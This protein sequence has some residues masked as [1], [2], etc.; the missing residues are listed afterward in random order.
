M[1][2]IKIGK[3]GKVII[4]SCIILSVIIVV[5]GMMLV[6]LSNRSEEKS[7]SSIKEVFNYKFEKATLELEEEPFSINAT[8]KDDFGIAIDSDFVINCK[9]Q[10]DYNDIK[11]NL[12]FEPEVSY[13]INKK[14]DKEFL[15][16]LKEPLTE[17]AIVKISLDD[18]NSDKEYSWAFQTK[19]KFTLSNTL[20][21][22]G[23]TS[24]PVDSGIELNFS[25]GEIEDISKHFEIEP[26]VEGEFEKKDNTYVFIPE[27]LDTNTIYNVTVK[28]DLALKNSE[29]KLTEDY[30]FSFQT[31]KAEDHKFSFNKSFYTLTPEQPTVLDVHWDNKYESRPLNVNVYR[32][33][34]IDSFIKILEQREVDNF[35]DYKVNANSLE[36]ITSFETELQS[37]E[38]DW[39]NEYIVFPE[40]LDAG[41]YLVEVVIDGVNYYTQLQVHPYVVYMETDYDDTLVWVNDTSSKGS[42]SNAYVEYE[43]EVKGVTNENGLLVFDKDQSNNNKPYHYYYKI[44]EQGEL[45]FV[46]TLGYYINNTTKNDYWDYM[47]TDRN[48]YLATDTI[49]VWGVIK[50]KNNNEFKSDLKVVLEK[51]DRILLEKNVD[52]SEIGSY[53][54]ALSYENLPHGYYK[55][56][57]MDEDIILDT[58]YINITSYDKPIYNLEAKVDKTKLF[59]WESTNLDID[60]KF[61]D[62]TPASGMELAINSY[63]PNNDKHHGETTCND[64][65]EASYVFEEDVKS[66]SWRPKWININVSN[67]QAEEVEVRTTESIMVFPKDT[68]IEIVEDEQ[69]QY[70]VSTHKIDYNNYEDDYKSLRDDKV[71]IPIDVTITEIEYLKIEEGTY[72]DFINKKTQKKYRYDKKETIVQDIS[73]ETENGVYNIEYEYEDDKN[74]EI[75]VKAKDSRGSNIVE[76][77]YKNEYSVPSASSQKNYSLEMTEPSKW[78]FGLEEDVEIS[79]KCNNADITDTDIDQTLFIQ[80]K[81]GRSNTFLK[82]NSELVFPYDEE[83]IPNIFLSAIY[84]DG[85]GLYKSR[86]EIIGYKSEEKELQF[87]IE[88]DKETYKPGD[89][90]NLNIKVSDLQG[91]PQKADI[92]IS[93]VDE[94]FFEL[95]NHEANIL[96][97]LYEYDSTKGVL[98][99]YISYRQVDDFESGAENGGEGDDGSLRSDFKDTAFFNSIE[100][101]EQGNA[102]FKF[103]LPDNL[104]NWRITCQGVTKDLFAGDE[105]ININTQLPFFV[106]TI[107]GDTFIKGDE[108]KISL[109]TFGM[110]VESDELIVYEIVLKDDEGNKQRFTINGKSH[111]YTLVDLGKLDIGS[112]T[113]ETFAEN[114]K[115]KDG[116]QKSFDVVD[117]TLKF[118]YTE[119][120]NLTED[121]KFEPTQSYEKTTFINADNYFVYDT[122]M[123][124]S[125]DYGNRVDQKLARYLSSKWLEDFNDSNL[126]NITKNDFNPHQSSGIRLLPYSD[127]DVALTAKINSL[128]TD[129]FD[130]NYV[131]FYKHILNKEDVTKKEALAALYGLSVAKEPVLLELNKFNKDDLDIEDKLYLALGYAE[132]GAYKEARN[133]YYELINDYGRETDEYLYL[134]DGKDW[135]DRIKVTALGSV[136]GAKLQEDEAFMM[137]DFICDYPSEYYLANI[138][139]LMFIKEFKI[140]HSTASFTYLLNEK[141]EKVKLDNLDIKQLYLSKDELENI[142]FKNIK[143]NVIV[144]KDGL[145]TVND[146]KDQVAKDFEIKRNYSVDN[147]ETTNFNQSEL[148]KVTLTPSF[149]TNLSKG[150]YEITDSIPAGFRYVSPKH[151][152]GY[153]TFGEVDSQIR[154]YFYYDPESKDPIDEITYY[155]RATT[156]G[157]YTADYA[158]IKSSNTNKLAHTEQAEITIVK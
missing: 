117:S 60:A 145:G 42:L 1:K 82:N 106:T 125:Y 122:L 131:S 109:R 52:L 127:S 141:E 2:R 154:F 153:Y 98:G 124:L 66:D 34:S 46:A 70:Q 128:E 87:E 120:Y 112:Y 67:N 9:N 149:N 115:Y 40:T 13:D 19:D 105:K 91:N 35:Y 44:Y 79:L 83:M 118:P 5:I 32:Y 148:I 85:E 130:N 8:K 45:P 103:T 28:K 65:G 92:N 63:I 99:E 10:T 136:L 155:V 129:V 142:K 90:V 24:V 29:E 137:F 12:K 54:E 86:D 140:K 18:K 80:Y 55:L 20:P 69:E 33:P 15:V 151:Y 152:R 61:F 56:R 72:Y 116:I 158:V 31:D 62:G 77:K 114:N 132:L 25:M 138:E 57:L 7:T 84:F 22:D 95:S 111:D 89:E 107:L 100:S 101:D 135:D 47:Y 123:K 94:A 43:G 146:I 23:A 110:D 26:S 36:K 147:F 4:G 48:M 126:S 121:I 88:T 156:P 144:V 97:K 14:S 64:N 75:K 133:I 21:R 11:S 157:Y 71:D 108:P 134:E 6:R 143:G 93:V 102:S 49:N 68:M 53:S 39:W 81:D 76:E 37:L 17:R 150:W 30:T 41:Y 104:T 96:S 78:R 16:A 139:K 113:I 3:N 74:Y 27:S 58:A 119:T 50:P 51:E 73:T 59:A 38:D